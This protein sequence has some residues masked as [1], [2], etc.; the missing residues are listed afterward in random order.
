[1]SPKELN[2]DR[3]YKNWL[4][5]LSILNVMGVG[6]AVWQGS[7][8]LWLALNICSFSY[9]ISQ[10]RIY[11]INFPAFIGYASW[12]T[13][14]RLLLLFVLGFLL[15]VLNSYVLFSLFAF[16]I[17]LDGLDGY[18]ARKF[19]HHSDLVARIDME[20]DA[21]LVMLLTLY[22][23]QE[24][25]IPQWILLPA[26][27]RF[28]VGIL[29]YFA[30]TKESPSRMFR[31]TIAEVTTRMFR[32]TIAVVFFVSLLFAFVL[33][34]DWPHYL[35]SIAGGLILLSFGLEIIGQ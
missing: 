24:Q 27:M 23:V 15:E 8:L 14:F 9:F 26:L 35:T 20:T 34:D 12:V 5:L 3:L 19:K 25:T 13:I 16:A 4:L 6:Y 31:N 10:M 22:H 28:L 11:L 17:A 29:T 33:P 2:S 18:L 30:M 32:A 21:F 7:I 1:M